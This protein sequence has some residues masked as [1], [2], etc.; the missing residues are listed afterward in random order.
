VK[1]QRPSAGAVEAA[2]LKPGFKKKETEGVFIVDKENKAQ[3]V[4]VKTGVAGDKYFEVLDGLKAGDR[5][6]TGPFAS[7][8]TLT[9]GSQVKVEGAK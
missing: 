6:I 4:Q 9:D 1:G 8:R 3:F 2:E 5:V 7:V